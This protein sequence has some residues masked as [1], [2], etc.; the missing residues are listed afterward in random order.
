MMV[1][2]KSADALQ[3]EMQI[4]RR[5]LNGHAGEMVETARTQLGWRHFVSHHP[6]MVVGAAAVVGYWLVPRRA[7]ACK[8]GDAAARQSAPSPLAGVA[9]SLL[10]AVTA[11][12]AREGLAL[13]GHL[14]RQWLD[15]REASSGWDPDRR[16]YS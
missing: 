4:V 3:E 5:N 11:T 8:E 6:W 9:A 16:D 10:G 14:A 1:C 2:Q 12:A 13:V 15:P 7:C